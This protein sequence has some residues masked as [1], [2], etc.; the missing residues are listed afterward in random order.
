MCPKLNG[1][2]V[3]FSMVLEANFPNY[4]GNMQRPRALNL[5]ALTP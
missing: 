1:F 3:K 5:L 2:E 4:P